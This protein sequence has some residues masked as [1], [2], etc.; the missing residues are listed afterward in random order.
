MSFSRTA[1]YSLN[2]LTCMASNEET[3]MSASLLN[4]KLKIPYPYLRQILAKL[5]KAGFIKSKRGRKGG[6][7]FSTGTDKITLADILDATDGLESYSSCLLEFM[8][9]RLTSIVPCMT[10]GKR[11]EIT[12]SVS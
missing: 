3:I 2:I 4:K 10:Y 5:S 8:E 9:C 1:S 12:S 11:P 7:I 6:F